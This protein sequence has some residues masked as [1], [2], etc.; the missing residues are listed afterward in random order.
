MLEHCWHT[1][2]LPNPD[3]FVGLPEGEARFITLENAFPLL[4]CPMAASFTP[5]QPTLGIAHGDLR[6]VC[7]CSA[8][9]THFMNLPTSVFVLT[10]L[11]EAVWNSVVSVATEDRLFFLTSALGCHIL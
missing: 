10:L 7:C 3:S 2:H 4:Q 5:L 9:E 11:Q 6:V 8:M 1:W